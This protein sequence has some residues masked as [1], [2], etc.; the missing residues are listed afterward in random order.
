VTSAEA[1]EE[2][3]RRTS[4][5]ELFFDLVFV[6][7]ITQVTTLITSQPTAA[8]FARAAL[9]LGLVWW[10]WS[11]YAWL[12]NAIEIENSGVRLAF[13]AAALGSFFMAL[14][15]PHAF[16]SQGAWFVVPYLAVRVLHLW[17]YVRGLRHDPAHQAAIK[18]L[19]PWFLI[20]PFV[21]FVGGVVSSTD[22]RTALWV[23]SLAIDVAGAL[24][25]GRAGFRVSPAHFAERYALFVIIALGESIVAIGV[26]AADDT[27]DLTF[28]IAVA[29]AFAGA[30][31]LWWAYFDF[32]AL[33]AE[34]SLRFA[35]PAER[36]RRARDVFTFFHYPQVLGI[37]FFAVGAKE[38]L[39]APLEPLSTSGR[40]ALVLGGS[41]P[42]LATVLGRYR[43]T[44]HVAWERVAGIAASALV[45]LVFRDLDA[46]WLLL[47]IVAI[48][49]ATIGA[50]MIRLREARRQI[51]SDGP[52]R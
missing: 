50:E 18:M 51:R 49:A 14:A 32:I 40:A 8:G 46:V 22:L 29:I 9:V 44:R 38:T 36:G 23:V 24:G 12:T 41:L 27:R 20:A 7:A 42:L 34:R 47:A 11:G 1:T 43:V 17:L 16:D 19:A 45:G 2:R 15:V 4:Y 37:I 28:A 30:A 13:L 39:A 25:V 10:A 35:P 52:P 31:A 21:A 3:E 6:F 26:G 5:L 48:L 33:A